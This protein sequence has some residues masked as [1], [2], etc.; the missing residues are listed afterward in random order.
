MYDDDSTS[1]D[2]GALEL[3]TSLDVVY[4][5][6][7]QKVSMPLVHAPPRRLV[8]MS[9]F[10]TSTHSSVLIMIAMPLGDAL[11]L[12]LRPIQQTQASNGADRDLTAMQRC[13][14]CGT[15]GI[16]S[17]G[18]STQCEVTALCATNTAASV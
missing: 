4:V 10:T 18:R 7:V 13:C 12:A 3:S 9:R 17:P 11:A 8:F 6:A 5:N 1:M 16:A 2:C 15:S 14:A